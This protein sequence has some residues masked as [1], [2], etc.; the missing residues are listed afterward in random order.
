MPGRAPCAP[1]PR[2]RWR[3]AAISGRSDRRSRSRPR[4]RSVR[5]TPGAIALT[6]MLS[7]RPLQRQRL[8]QRAH[9]ALGAGVGVGAGGA[10]HRAD[11]G[12]VDDRAAAARDH[13]R[14][15]EAA[16]EEGPEQVDPDRPPELL[17]RDLGDLA[18]PRRGAARVV[19]ED[20][21]AAEA[22]DRR[23]DRGFDARGLAD[24]GRD[25]QRLAARVPDRP[26]GRF[27]FGAGDLGHDHPGTFGREQP[28][29]GPAD[30]L[31][32]A[33]DQRESSRPDDPRRLSS[34]PRL[35]TGRAWPSDPPVSRDRPQ[36]LWPSRQA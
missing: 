24:V 21:Q 36:P 11:R 7:R 20:V 34:G 16:A 10:D 32:G 22:L 5:I 33:G 1:R 31:P 23:P 30:A 26:H 12:R 6:R 9:A 29:R 4:T 2:A 17:E 14:D 35:A 18:V 8:G 25:E 3:R 28:G 27:A 15:R 19:V 13:H